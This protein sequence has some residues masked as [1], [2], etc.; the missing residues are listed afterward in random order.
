MA[1]DVMLNVRITEKMKAAIKRKAKKD[2]R[3]MSDWV[4]LVI[5]RELLK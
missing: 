3:T 1:K 4:V 2:D 5:A